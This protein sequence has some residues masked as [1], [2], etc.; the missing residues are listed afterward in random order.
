M[1]RILAFAIATI[2]FFFLPCCRLIPPYQSPAV[3]VS[4]EWKHQHTQ[5]NP[6][7]PNV[8]FWWEIF[9]DET[10]NELEQQAVANNYN[11]EIAVERIIQ[12]RDYAKIVRS[13]LFPHI[14]LFPIYHNE[15]VLTKLFSAK[16]TSNKDKNFI[17][18]HKLLYALPLTLSYELDLW[19]KL[20]GEYRSALFQAR[21]QEQ[22]FQTALL[23]VTTDLAAAYFQLRVQ[24]TLI[25]LF[26]KTIET[27]KKALSI[28]QAR[29]EEQIID[30]SAVALAEL[31]LH[32]VETQYYEALRQR[33]L[34]EDQI[35][36]LIGTSPSE[37]AVDVQL[38]TY[39]PPEIPVNLPS[40]I[41]LQRPDLAAQEFTIASVYE[42]I[43]VAYAST[44]PSIQLTG[45]AGFSSP[46]ARKFATPESRYWALGTNISQYIFDAGAR[47]YNVKLTWSEFRE[48]ISVYQQRIL[49]AF[50]E[51][52]DALSNL[53]L[54][55]KEVKSTQKS[56]EAAHKAYKI[57][58]DQ[59][60]T[61]FNFYL[62]VADNERQELDNQR[63]YYYLQGLRYLNTIQ[64]IK[65]LG[66]TWKSS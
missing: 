15:F 32:N 40:E 11:L 62:A 27:R 3:P 21:A 53:D 64:L 33:A 46:I 7:L 42:Q 29:Y 44:F 47:Y 39:E 35:A 37:F 65:A 31:D 28:N 30:Y 66:G 12:A 61:G 1:P 60:I 34:L 2:F 36:V 51:V 26:S 63:I 8:D 43:G 20:R 52:E 5:T 10:L 50:Q 48:A 24:D 18:E 4:S 17:R 25:D 38:I 59:Y 19:G 45:T 49:V 13:E 6:S 23:V 22:D 54:L 9:E 16:S 58:L 55:I 41:L 57:S 14:N 56:V